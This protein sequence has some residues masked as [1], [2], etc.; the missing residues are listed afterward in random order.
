MVPGGDS[1][2]L[3]GLWGTPISV[4]SAPNPSWRQI[5]SRGEH[6]DNPQI[7]YKHS[8]VG[9]KLGC[10]LPNTFCPQLLNCHALWWRQSHVYLIHKRWFPRGLV[11][12]IQ[13]NVYFLLKKKNSLSLNPGSWVLSR[14]TKLEPQ[15]KKKKSENQFKTAQEVLNP[16]LID[17]RHW[18]EIFKIRSKSLMS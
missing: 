13:E 4:L 3:G 14:V 9:R 18:E 1:P 17:T 6:I 10:V 11:Y 16:C 12:A 2:S 8:G 7:L 5:W 15:A